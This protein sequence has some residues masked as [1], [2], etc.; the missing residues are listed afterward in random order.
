[1]LKNFFTV[2]F[3]IISAFSASAS[4]NDPLEFC[5]E[6]NLRCAMLGT[7]V[8]HLQGVEGNTMVNVP[9]FDSFTE[10]GKEKLHSYIPVSIKTDINDVFDNLPPLLQDKVIELKDSETPID[11]ALSMQSFPWEGDENISF[12]AHPWMARPKK[13]NAGRELLSL[14]ILDGKSLEEIKSYGTVIFFNLKE[15]T[16]NPSRGSMFVGKC[17]DLINRPLW[18]ITTASPERAYMRSIITLHLPL[19]PN[20]ALALQEVFV[21]DPQNLSTLYG[22]LS[23]NDAFLG[24][25]IF[26]ALAPL[27]PIRHID[28]VEE[29]ILPDCPY[30]VLGDAFKYMREGNKDL[31]FEPLDINMDIFGKI[32]PEKVAVILSSYMEQEYSLKS[33][34]KFYILMMAINE[35]EI[36]HNLELENAI[37]PPLYSPEQYSI[38]KQV[39]GFLDHSG[40]I[41]CIAMGDLSSEERPNLVKILLEWNEKVMTLALSDEAL[42]AICKAFDEEFWNGY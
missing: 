28:M 36:D 38:V 11:F 24:S 34:E 1:M 14:D 27:V 2:C 9:R 21:D 10:E 20:Q 39:F 23:E 7:E 30:Q 5:V 33:I 22:M 26:E 37:N 6:N 12:Y 40:Q 42:L 17:E 13:L 19:H 15:R 31:G 18:S 32:H 16:I 35:G 8:S 4:I 41:D 29:V 3:S 25:P